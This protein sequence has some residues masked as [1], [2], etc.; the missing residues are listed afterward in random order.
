MTTLGT[1]VTFSSGNGG[2]ITT[3]GD[4]HALREYGVTTDGWVYFDDLSFNAT[5][6]MSLDLRG[7]LTTAK[8]THDTGDEVFT[9]GL[10]SRVPN[11]RCDIR[12]VGL[13]AK[14]WYRLQFDGQLA[15][16]SAGYAH[17]TTGISDTIQFNGVHVPE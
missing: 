5:H 4:T 9:F 3:I 2:T 7:K 17:G 16:T 6:D 10:T 13:P 8:I 11:G 14:Q 1:G 12:G 15:R